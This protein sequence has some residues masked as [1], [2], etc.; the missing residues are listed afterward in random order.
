[1]QSIH[2][3]AAIAL[4]V[5]RTRAAELAGAPIAPDP[6]PAPP[7]NFYPATAAEILRG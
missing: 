6:T 4:S 2:N 1:M 7:A 3:F 5:A